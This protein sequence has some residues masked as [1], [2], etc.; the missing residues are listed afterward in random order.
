[1]LGRNRFDSAPIQAHGYSLSTD[2]AVRKDA[3]AYREGPLT[4]EGSTS[5]VTLHVLFFTTFS[6]SITPQLPFLLTGGAAVSTTGQQSPIPMYAAKTR[7]ISLGP[8]ESS[9]W[10]LCLHG[11]R[12]CWTASLA[13]IQWMVSLSQYRRLQPPLFTSIPC[14]CIV[15]FPLI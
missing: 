3:P 7:F 2:R 1:M 12:R 13:V 15:S 9:V 8:H 11:T 10:L 6:F 14:Q 5:S 4:V